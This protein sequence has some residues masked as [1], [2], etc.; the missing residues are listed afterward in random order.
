MDLYFKEFL[1]PKSVKSNMTHDRSLGTLADWLLGEN[2]ATPACPKC[3][4]PTVLRTN[5]ANGNKFYGCSGYPN[6]RGTVGYNPNVA[7]SSPA[8]AQPPANIQ[9]SQ[10]QATNWIY[11]KLLASGEDV[12]IKRTNNG[13]WAYFG[14]IN[15]KNNGVVK[16]SEAQANL[17][18]YRVDNVPITSTN[19][20]MEDLDH[21]LG[22]PPTQKLLASSKPNSKEVKARKS[23]IIP[24]HFISD[25]QKM[26]DQ[27]FE[28]LMAHPNQSHM[29]INALAGSGKTSLLNHIAEKYGNTQQKWLYLVFNT[30]NKVEAK[31]KFPSFVDV[32]TTNGF[33]GEVLKHRSNVTSMKQTERM[34]ELSKY[35]KKG[36]EKEKIVE[37]ARLLTDG[38]EFAAMMEKHG[39]RNNPN[40]SEYG[41]MGKT[42]SS[43]LKSISIEFKEQVVKLAGLAKSFAVD[44]RIVGNHLETELKKVMDQYDFETDLP[45]I[46]E[47]I[48]RYGG[49]Y[50]KNVIEALREVMGYNFM[51]KDYR[52]EVIDG[53]VWLLLKT[54]P[55][56]TD[57]TYRQNN[58]DYN[59][60]ELRDFNDDLWYAAVHANEIN[61][62]RFDVV[63]ADEVQDFNEAQKIML[64]KLHDA[65]AK[66]VAVGDPNQ[67]IYRFRG[68][69]SKAF[70]NI[71]G[72]LNDLSHNKNT[73]Y[74]LTKNFRSRKA[75]I[76]FANSETHVKNLIQGKKFNDGWDGEATKDKVGYDD[77]F[78]TLQNEHKKGQL[79]QTAFIARTNEPLVHAA[80]KLLAQG[81]P[82]LVVGKDIA[83]DLK[84]H[85]S[86]IIGR[87][88]MS[89]EYSTSDLYDK[90][91]EFSDNEH[92]A[93][94]G[95]ATKKAYLGD[96]KEVTGALESSIGQFEK[97]NNG[98]GDIRQFKNWLSQ[99]MGGLEV[100]DN[101]KD[102]M[103]Y[104]EKLEKENPVILTT[105][106]KS[107]GLEFSRVF[108][109]R[110]D[111]FP[112]PKA[113]RE[114]DKLQEENAKY[115]ALT[116]AED[117]IHVL[118]LKGQP[119][120]KED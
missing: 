100:D 36:A 27:Q 68:A 74:Q 104:R 97:E 4:S 14:I 28:Q 109:L 111:R 11:A 18:T 98:N 103:A 80:L 113:K 58:I 17:Q 15:R 42:I 110:Y 63:M 45:D 75:V 62:P 19:P 95:K 49:S 85:I 79:K 99:K 47:R 56:A 91:I 22:R 48:N 40:T 71:G 108:I 93:H 61:W 119:G 10:P 88:G 107:K 26:V 53:A 76:D 33:L 57:Q 24:D 118:K 101:E 20:S 81:V 64:K 92:D 13:D 55:H 46:K 6:C 37:K 73:N 34:S 84:K 90:I 67:S 29:M 12:V 60:G 32:K 50:S 52:N 89:D 51:M 2:Q 65:G 16:A 87:F 115:V 3:G 25:E 96:L 117:E 54:M 114:E 31:E 112:H 1:Y 38:P 82:F 21:R 78:S 105:A 70:G 39:I 66:I 8:V 106:H 120:V 23:G 102:L 35:N 5:R 9:P 41:R 72:Q 69:D 30:K 7:A 44:P 43:L 116:R 83:N 86:K 59:L 77:A 94:E